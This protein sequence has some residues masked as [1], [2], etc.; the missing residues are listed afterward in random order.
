MHWLAVNIRYIYA[1]KVTLSL[2]LILIANRDLSIL[3]KQKQEQESGIISV[4]PAV[5]L[6][7]MCKVD[8]D[9]LSLSAPKRNKN[10]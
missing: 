6:F 1:F 9:S 4:K 2:C 5:A 3:K 10:I 7:L 8:F